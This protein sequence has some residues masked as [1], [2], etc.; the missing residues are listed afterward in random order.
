VLNA[1]N[2]EAVAAFLA[3]RLPFPAIAEVVAGVLAAHV[4]PAALSIE[5]VLGAERWSREL[6]R[7]LVSDRSPPGR[8]HE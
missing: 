4:Q 1:A 3:G 8:P 7:T 6:A 2:E 5:A